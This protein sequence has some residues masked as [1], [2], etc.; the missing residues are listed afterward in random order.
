L[1]KLGYAG[2]DSPIIFIKLWLDFAISFQG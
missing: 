2:H 1:I